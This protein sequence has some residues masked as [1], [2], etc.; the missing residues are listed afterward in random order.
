MRLITLTG[1]NH[2]HVFLRRPFHDPAKDVNIRARVD[3]RGGVRK[4]RERIRGRDLGR[5]PGSC[6]SGE[7]GVHNGR[8]R[9]L[10]R[11]IV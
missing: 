5:D 2:M 9:G 8:G 4:A 10:V 7:G 6:G 3:I 11:S 1:I